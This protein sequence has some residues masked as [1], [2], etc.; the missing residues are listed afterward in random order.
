[1]ARL[2]SQ[3]S[4]KSPRPS[5]EILRPLPYVAVIPRNLLANTANLGSTS[6]DENMGVAVYIHSAEK[7]RT[8]CCGGV[9]RNADDVE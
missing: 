3:V 7:S 4:R 5:H 2:S 9:G 6:K 8:E 1:M